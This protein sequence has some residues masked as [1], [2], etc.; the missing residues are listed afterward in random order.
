MINYQ[1]PITNYQLPI[2]NYQ[3]LVLTLIVIPHHPSRS[4]A[5]SFN[6]LM[7]MRSFLSQHI[8]IIKLFS[9][10]GIIYYSNEHWFI[11]IA[12]NIFKLQARK[13]N[14]LI[15]ICENNIN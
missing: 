5:K 1:L 4:S 3:L 12:K 11:I 9:C 15:N 7:N 14:T 2:T 13:L 8:S 10:N 6:K